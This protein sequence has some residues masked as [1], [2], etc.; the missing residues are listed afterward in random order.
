MTPVAARRPL[1]Y[2]RARAAARQSAWRSRQRDGRA[3]YSVT[4]DDIVIALLVHLHWLQEH[5]TTDRRAV[6]KAISELLADAAHK[7]FP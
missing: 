2:R 6:S 1:D 3:V 4:I 7:N 5:Q